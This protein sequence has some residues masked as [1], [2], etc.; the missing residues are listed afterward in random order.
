MTEAEA[1][2]A[3]AAVAKNWPDL[4]YFGFMA[5]GDASA[6]RAELLRATRE[7][8][9]AFA[10]LSQVTKTASFNPI[11]SYD[12]KEAAELWSGEYIANGVFIAAAIRAGIRVKRIP[13]TPNAELGISK[14]WPS[15]PSTAR[16]A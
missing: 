16:R 8:Q 15:L 2:A 11:S 14:A 13:G 5:P 7:F 9:V 4:G 1:K 6:Q 3:L 10:W 12:I